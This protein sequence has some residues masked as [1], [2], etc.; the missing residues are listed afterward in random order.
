MQS[1]LVQFAQQLLQ[2]AASRMA[3]RSS[4]TKELQ[5]GDGGV[6]AAAAGSKRKRQQQQ[7]EESSDEQ[8]ADSGDEQGELLLCA[9]AC[10]V[11]H[12]GCLAATCALIRALRRAVLVLA[13]QQMALQTATCRA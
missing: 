12:A 7:Q 10:V 4:A 2:K 1:P 9:G 3:L 11:S 6:P 8:E 5:L 13:N